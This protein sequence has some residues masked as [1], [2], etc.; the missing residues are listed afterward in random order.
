MCH[1]SYVHTLILTQKI[2][3][4]SRLWERLYLVC[5]KILSFDLFLLTNK[6]WLYP[7]NKVRK[8]FGGD[9][10][11]FSD[12]FFCFKNL[13]RVINL[14][15]ISLFSIFSYIFVCTEN[16]TNNI[17]KFASTIKMLKKLTFIMSVLFKKLKYQFCYLFTQILTILS[18]AGQV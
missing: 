7:S 3:L 2:I 10:F 12:K 6:P 15:L 4:W 11:W 13:T 14:W 8:K 16:I 5:H 9:I 18:K 1:T 17:L